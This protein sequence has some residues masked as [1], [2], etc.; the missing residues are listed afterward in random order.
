MKVNRAKEIAQRSLNKGNIRIKHDF[1]G[2]LFSDSSQM[3][4]LVMYF[5][6]QLKKRSKT[7]SSHQLKYLNYIKPKN[8]CCE[9]LRNS[10]ICFD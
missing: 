2:A 1:P 8:K 10:N 4:I 6:L 5:F 7:T 3:L 9:Y